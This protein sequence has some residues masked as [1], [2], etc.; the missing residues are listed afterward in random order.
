MFK[1]FDVGY[2]FNFKYKRYN[3]RANID[4]DLTKSTLLSLNLGGRVA[5]KNTPISNEDQEQLFRQLY[6]ATP[7]G[8]AGIVNGKRVLTNEKLISDPG[9]DGLYPYYG[10]GYDAKA[11]NVLN[12]DLSLK[13]D[14]D[15][16]TKGLYFKLKGSYNTTYYHLKEYSGSIA[17]YYPKVSGSEVQ[18]TEDGEVALTKDGDDTQLSFY[19]EYDIDRDWYAEASFNYNREFG[20][21][22]IGGLLLYTQSKYYYPDDYTDIPSG[23][24]GLVGR[25]TYDWKTKYMAEF[26][27]GYNGSE[28]F[29]RENRYGFFPAGSVGWVVT[30]EN[31]M[32]PLQGII[33]YMKL[34]ASYGVVGNDKYGSSRFL[35]IPDSYVVD[36]SDDG[37]NFGSDNSSNQSGAYESSIS[38]ADVTWEKAYKQNYGVDLA[39]V[40]NK[41][42]VSLD[43]FK[44]HRVDILGENSSSPGYLGVDLPAVNIGVVDNHGYEVLL[45]WNDKLSSDFR[46]W[47][48]TNLSFARNKI[49]EEGEVEPNE[50]YMRETG[51][52]IGSN[53]IYSFWGFYDDTAN[54]R[55]KEQYGT[56]IAEHSVDLEPGDV[57]YVDLNDDGVI[58]SDDI[59]KHGYTNSP[60]Y[61]VGAS[62]GFSWRNL[63]FSMQWTGAWNASRMLQETFLEPLGETNDRGLLLYQYDERWTEATASTAKLPRA[64]LDHKSNNYMGSSLFLVDASYLR[65]KNVEIGYNLNIRA[66]KE[67]GMGKC[68]LFVNGY[69]LLT[70]TGFRY[71]DPESKTSSRPSYPLTRVFNAGLKIGF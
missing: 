11:T 49:I 69:N 34:R 51:R 52:P 67:I 19:E 33:N 59:T 21:H 61:T 27:V 30:E 16:V 14:L 46:Y 66:F 3:Y 26:N 13:Q 50:P 54:E 7:F 55:Y 60:E 2:D 65:L 43:V 32:K 39:F 29:A 48:S 58:D 1:T 40:D 31:F 10:K 4:Y 24:V 62:A 68:R 42:K 8:G 22:T 53:I 38:N 70:F 20:G 9:V 25:A 37:Y 17:A 57:V 41:F 6:W 28:N 64:T 12:I 44:E 23:Y 18:Y 71:G 35:Y 63:D 36:S 45:K 56:D 5:N 15:F 47:V